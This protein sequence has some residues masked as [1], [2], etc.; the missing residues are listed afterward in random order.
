[1]SKS[2]T[3]GVKWNFDDTCHILGD[4][5]ASVWDTDVAISGCLT[6]SHLFVDTFV[7]LPVLENFAF[8]TVIRVI[9]TLDAFCWM[10][11]YELKMLPL[12]K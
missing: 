9:L 12:S 4:I 6:V 11:R 8:T 7:E 10:S 2:N 1:M 3:P 5:S